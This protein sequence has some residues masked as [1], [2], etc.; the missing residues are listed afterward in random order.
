MEECDIEFWDRQHHP[1]CLPKTPCRVNSS[2]MGID[3][4]ETYLI[5]AC[6]R[7]KAKRRPSDRS[8]IGSAVVE[9]SAIESWDRQHPLSAFAGPPP[10][11]CSDFMSIDAT[12]TSLIPACSWRRAQRRPN[13][14]LK[15]SPA[16][17]EE[18]AIEFRIAR[19]LGFLKTTLRRVGDLHEY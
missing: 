15:I 13:N 3:A 16:V 9:E 1:F 14:R 19:V 2:F 8:R 12:V 10:R 7:R 18:S 17:V 4:I 11:L 5:P 6:S